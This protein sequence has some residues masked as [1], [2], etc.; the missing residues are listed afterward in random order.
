M[1]KYLLAILLTFSISAGNLFSLDVEENKSGQPFLYIQN[2]TEG[3]IFCLIKGKYYF[4]MVKI[5]ALKKSR[6]YPKPKYNYKVTCR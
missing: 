1:I 2:L 3:S 4:K 6:P 5:K